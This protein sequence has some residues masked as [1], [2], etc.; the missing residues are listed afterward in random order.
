MEIVMLCL[1]VF[2]VRI[3]DVSLGT[4]RTMLMVKEKRIVATII[5]FFEVLIWFLVV[6]EALNTDSNSIWIAISYALGFA[7]GTYLGMIFSDRYIS[8][9]LEIQIITENYQKLSK[10]LRD[11]NF[12]V[13]ATKVV[14]MDTKKDK[15]MLYIAISSKNYPKLNKILKEYDKQAFLVI[16]ESKYIR[17]GYFMNNLK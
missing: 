12:A 10:A 11:N 7:T 6:K 8:E 1:K 9:L 5:G 14:G 15:Y 3:I 13:T 2:F 17:N 4:F 16:N